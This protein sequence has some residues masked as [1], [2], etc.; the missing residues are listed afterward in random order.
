[1]PVG[2]YTL[3]DGVVISSN[4]HVRGDGPGTFVRSKLGS[5]AGQSNLGL[6]STK[7]NA[8]DI[9]ISDMRLSGRADE[10]FTYTDTSSWGTDDS[11]KAVWING[12]DGDYPTTH[13]RRLICDSLYC[14]QFGNE[15]LWGGAQDSI[16]S[17]CYAKDS[18]TGLVSWSVPGVTRWILPSFQFSGAHC[19]YIGNYT[20]GC[21]TGIGASGSSPVI[22]GNT[23]INP[24]QDGIGVGDGGHYE[25]GLISGN[26]IE[27]TS[28]GPNAPKGITISGSYSTLATTYGGNITITGNTIK[29]LGDENDTET[30]RGIYLGSIIGGDDGDD[31]GIISVVGNTIEIRECGIGIAWTT[32]ATNENPVDVVSRKQL[33]NSSRDPYTTT[34]ETTIHDH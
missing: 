23:I 15:V 31:A 9:K 27:I 3:S 1:M 20:N 26:Y 22:V 14:E 5:W 13:V 30:A 24:I 10:Q 6:F 32:H 4:T 2:T 7:A 28:A 18:G 16:I 25:T 17:N 29:V 33:P 21:G 34:Y 8:T 11:P 12:T 19:R